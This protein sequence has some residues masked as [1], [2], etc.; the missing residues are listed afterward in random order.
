MD[1]AV[2]IFQY[3]NKPESRKKRSAERAHYLSKLTE[4]RDE[5]CISQ[6]RLNN[7]S[8]DYLC[9]MLKVRGLLKDT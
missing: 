1:A 7:A 6:L 8:F 9:E 5:E 3:Q 4:G 2:V